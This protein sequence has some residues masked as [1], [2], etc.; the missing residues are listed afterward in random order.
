MIKF[1]LFSVECIALNINWQEKT[2]SIPDNIKYFMVNIEHY[3]F[4]D[5][6]DNEPNEKNEPNETNLDVSFT[7][8][9]I[10]SYW[11]ENINKYNKIY[12]INFSD[13][14][15]GIDY[16]IAPLYVAR[17]KIEDIIIIGVFLLNNNKIKYNTIKVNTSST[18]NIYRFLSTFNNSLLKKYKI[19]SGILKYQIEIKK[20][21]D[22]LNKKFI[23]LDSCKYKYKYKIPMQ[24]ILT[25]ACNYLPKLDII[26]SCNKHLQGSFKIRQIHKT[27]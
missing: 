1:E 22:E 15:I 3:N 2:I 21:Y 6:D 27:T 4:N 26:V 8:S 24:Y 11:F 18:S 20:N 12:N 14:K 13:L 9:D 10:S 5:E 23:I 17:T 19:F 25:N 16:S 7:F